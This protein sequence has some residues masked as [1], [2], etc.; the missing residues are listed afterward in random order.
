[1]QVNGHRFAC[2]RAVLASR[3]RYFERLLCPPLGVRPPPESR[4]GAGAVANTSA[5]GGGG[6][7]SDESPE[8]SLEPPL[9]A[10]GAAPSLLGQ[11]T[12]T[13]AELDIG[14]IAGATHWLLIE[15]ALQFLYGG[16]CQFLAPDS[17]HR[18]TIVLQVYFSLL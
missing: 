15:Q 12:T 9:L 5:D 1:M 6:G 10:S 2:H 3:S 18:T 14:E 11:A 4:A 17:S 8:T 7:V 13:T 16:S